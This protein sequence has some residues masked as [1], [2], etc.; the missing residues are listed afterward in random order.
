MKFQISNCKFQISFTLIEVLVGTSLILIIFLGIFGAYELGLKVVGQATARVIATAIGNEWLEEIRN[1]PYEKVGIKNGYPDGILDSSTTTI[2]NG[3]TFTINTRID[4]KDDEKDGVA[5][6]DNCPNDYKLVKTKVSWSARFSGEV[7]LDTIVSPRNTVQECAQKGGELK[8]SVFDNSVYLAK[9]ERLPFPSIEVKNLNTGEIKTAQPESGLHYF[10]LAPGI[11]LYKVTVTKEN[12]S[13]DETFGIGDVYQGKTIATP[14][15]PNPNIFEGG[16]TETSFTIDKLSQFL[17]YTLEAKAKKIYYARKTVGSDD[18]DGLSPDTAFLTIQKAADIAEAGDIVFVGAGTYEEKIEIENSGSQNNYISF[19]ADSGGNYTGDKGEVKIKG[20]NYGFYIDGKKY[21]K[22]YGFKI[23]NSS[24]S[25]IQI[26]SS[27]SGNIEVLANTI[28]NNSGKGIYIED[29]SDILISHNNIFSNS[30]GIYLNKANS[31]QIIKNEVYNNN[32]EG[33]SNEKSNNVQIKFNKAYSNLKNGILVFKNAENCQVS[34]NETFSNGE[35]GIQISDNS[36]SI[37]VILNKSYSNLGVGISFK[38]HISN[39]NKIGSNLVYL[40]KKSGILLS[41]NSVNTTISNNTSFQNQEN[42]ILIE[43]DSNNNKL[44][45]NIVVKN[46]L[47]GIRVSD[48]INLETK[49]SDVWQNSL[50]YNGISAGEGSISED[51]LFIN[52]DNNDFHLSQIEAGQATTSP[53]VNSGSANVDDLGMNDK[54]T[55]TDNVLDS[56]TVDMGFHYSLESP[57]PL[58]PAPDPFGGPIPNTNFDLRGDKIVGTDASENPIYKYS[59]STSTDSNGFL[60]I[61]N[62]ENDL[63]TSSNFKSAGIS[64]DLIV[65]Y[66]APATEGKTKVNLVPDSTT[67][68]KL[69]LRAENTLLVKVRDSQT[70][71][72]IFAAS[73]RLYKTG[74]DQTKFTDGNGE[75]YFIPLEKTTYKLEVS[76]GGYTALT[77]NVSVNGHATEIISLTKL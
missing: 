70:T 14:E 34:E 63:Y 21:I 6:A 1:L 3:I 59:V 30:I 50:N 41:D 29:A 17:I 66:P 39:V 51:P 71:N 47:V 77:T 74:Y 5:P 62:L 54:T 23:E 25:A 69:G 18:N 61:K 9:G 37:S 28:S 60:N 64:L 68:V 76:A 72:P 19:V 26:I 27:N 4:Y 67:T 45:D 52:P 13:R 53:C 35:D 20:E 10:V 44:K 73:V 24:S 38:N 49:Y 22:I 48:S 55:R 31:S 7:F 56:E 40:N 33:I 57:P 32:L 46:N 58:P 8:V 42:G 65:S 11:S 43:N 16:L 15:N 75:V 2:R 12:Y 36:A